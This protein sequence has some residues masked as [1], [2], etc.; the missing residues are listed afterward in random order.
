MKPQRILLSI[1][2]FAIALFLSAFFVSAHPGKTDSDG[3]H[4]NHS[5]GEYH[6]HHG[7]EAHQHTDLDGD[8][9]A[10]CPFDFDEPAGTNSGFSSRN[11]PEQYNSDVAHATR[12]A[13]AAASTS[14]DSSSPVIV[15]DLLYPLL[16]LF[17][18]P[19]IIL[20]LSIAFHM[21]E[22]RYKNVSQFFFY[23][24]IILWIPTFPVST[25]AI[26]PYLHHIK[27]TKAK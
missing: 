27:R 17:V 4:N 20:S 3:G 22:K 24:S 19:L 10:D 14:Q 18:S 16:C 8:G 12:S 21:D 11:P 13:E 7:Y 5:T 25:F 1:G 23:L 2:I 9:I 15:T 6:Y 26:F